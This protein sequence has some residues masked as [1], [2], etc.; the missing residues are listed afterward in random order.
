MNALHIWQNVIA[1]GSVTTASGICELNLLRSDPVMRG[2][3]GVI[4]REWVDRP[5]VPNTNAYRRPQFRT[6]GTN[7]AAF[8]SARMR[9]SDPD[10]A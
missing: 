1:S 10:H 9:P 5:I 2:R 3:R 6:E 8:G 7:S 4:E